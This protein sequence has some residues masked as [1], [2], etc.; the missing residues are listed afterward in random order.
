[1][2]KINIVKSQFLV[3]LVSSY[4]SLGAS[5]C[6]Q[7]GN[8]FVELPSEAA[9]APDLVNGPNVCFPSGTGGPGTTPTDAKQGIYGKLYALDPAKSSLATTVDGLISNADALAN[10]YF[11]DFN[12]PVTSFD[13]GFRIGPTE[14]LQDQKKNTL[15]EW[16]GIDTQFRVKLRPAADSEGYYQF[17][18][19]SDDG[20]L[21]YDKN[22][23][24]QETL[25]VGND[26]LHL[27]QFKCANR[28]VHLAAGE[29]FP[30]RLKYYQGPRFLIEL[31]LLWRK[32]TPEMAQADNLACGA[33]SDYQALKPENYFLPAGFTEN[34]CVVKP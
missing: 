1:M 5:S 9:P 32:V 17:A 16:F 3:A 24:S 34:P 33:T 22:I 18:T 28:A 4:L 11:N 7:T 10:I 23:M 25:L 19:D 12:V 13:Q 20:S 21:V 15:I 27:P 8:E 6:G 26:G 2:K 31:K 29:L 14:Y 30:M